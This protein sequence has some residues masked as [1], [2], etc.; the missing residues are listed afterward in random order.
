MSFNPLHGGHISFVVQRV[1]HLPNNTRVCTPTN[2]FYFIYIFDV[3]IC[4]DEL[5]KTL[6]TKHYTTLQGRYQ[7]EQK[8]HDYP[9]AFNKA[10]RRPKIQVTIRHK[11]KKKIFQERGEFT[12]RFSL[13]TYSKRLEARMY[14]SVAVNIFAFESNDSCSWPWKM[15]FNNSSFERFIKT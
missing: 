6:T 2:N 8:Y 11:M 4:N 9:L 5:P 10:H 3:N 14:S 13:P 12:Y 15:I 1:S 7:G